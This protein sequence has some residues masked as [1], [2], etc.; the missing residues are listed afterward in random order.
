MEAHADCSWAEAMTR[1]AEC[2]REGGNEL[3]SI[4]SSGRARKPKDN[5]VEGGEESDDSGFVVF[6][7]HEV[8]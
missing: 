5:V 4:S 7:D 3:S 1:A 2:W 8:L 6:E